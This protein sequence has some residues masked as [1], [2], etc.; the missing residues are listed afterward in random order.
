MYPGLMLPVGGR[1]WL[2]IYP[3]FY[4]LLVMAPTGTLVSHLNVLRS[5]SWAK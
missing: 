4:S 5:I 2:L 1:Y 3:Y